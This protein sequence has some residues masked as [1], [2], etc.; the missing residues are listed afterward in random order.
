MADVFMSNTLPL[1]FRIIMRIVENR[2]TT[3]VVSFIRTPFSACQWVE[4]QVK[5]ENGCCVRG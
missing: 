4:Q 5:L 1:D 3:G 2:I